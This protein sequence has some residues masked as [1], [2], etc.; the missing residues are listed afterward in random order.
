[1]GVR[2]DMAH[3][4]WEAKL[5]S[6]RQDSR[7]SVCKGQVHIS[8][9]EAGLHPGSWNSGNPK[10][11]EDRLQDPGTPWNCIQNFICIYVSGESVHRE[12]HQISERKVKNH[13]CGVSQALRREVRGLP[14]I[15]EG[16]WWRVGMAGPTSKGI[17]EGGGTG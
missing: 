15:L 10:T 4:F 16:W 13:S 6:G 7:A 12:T 9:L 1:M 2:T 11:S 17:P 14:G 5:V 3:S 8:Y